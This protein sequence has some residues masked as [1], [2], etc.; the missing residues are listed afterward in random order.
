MRDKR[1][2]I[3]PLLRGG[4]F[5]LVFLERRSG[6]I[7][8]RLSGGGL[9][10]FVENEPGGH[11]W[12]EPSGKKKVIHTSTITIAVLPENKIDVVKLNIKD[13]RIDSYIATGPGGQ[14]RNKTASAVRATHLP[15]G[16]VARSESERSQHINKEYALAAL[17]AKIQDKNRREANESRVAE[18]KNQVGLG[19]RGCKVRS[20]RMQDDVLTCHR[21]GRKYSVKRYLK[22]ELPWEQNR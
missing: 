13:V 10:K 3:L 21:D 4:V 5:D 7:V 12:Q 11:R 19:M 20:I 1:I 6:F 8:I 2:F 22:G 18:R 17:T 15:T 16:I 14:H 9:D